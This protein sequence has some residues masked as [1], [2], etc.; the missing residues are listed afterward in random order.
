[1]DWL[2]SFNEYNSSSKKRYKNYHKLYKLQNHILLSTF[3]CGQ[4]PKASA[5]LRVTVQ[6]TGLSIFQQDDS[7]GNTSDVFNKLSDR[8]SAS[9]LGT[10]KFF[11]VFLNL[12]RLAGQYL[13]ICQELFFISS[14]QSTISDR[15]IWYRGVKMRQSGC[16][17]WS[18]YSY[19]ID[20]ADSS[21]H[22][23]INI[24]PDYLDILK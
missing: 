18:Y 22:F 1:M 12:F 3:K 23:N 6:K 14:C 19:C 21:S 11:V 16:I 20:N 24:W 2:G 4:H 13:E 8:I 15:C 17:H 5:K 10:T 7:D 9:T